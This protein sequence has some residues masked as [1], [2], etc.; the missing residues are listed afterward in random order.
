MSPLRVNMPPRRSFDRSRTR[1]RFRDVRL[2]VG[3]S[4]FHSHLEGGQTQAIDGESR[5]Y[6]ENAMTRT[7]HSRVSQEDALPL[8]ELPIVGVIDS[9]NQTGRVAQWWSAL[10]VP[11][12][13]RVRSAVWPLFPSTPIVVGFTYSNLTSK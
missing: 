6:L 5:T 12:K 8:P 11:G 3:A 13:S 9:S 2:A 4:R 7:A 1:Y 10:H